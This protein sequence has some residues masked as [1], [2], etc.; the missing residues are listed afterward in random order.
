[1]SLINI[2]AAG[3]VVV[4]LPVLFYAVICVIAI[5]TRMRDPYE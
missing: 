1:M 5:E 2:L 4:A 3:F